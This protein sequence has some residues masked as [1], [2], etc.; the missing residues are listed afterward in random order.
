M[1]FSYVTHSVINDALNVRLS[2]FSVV[3]CFVTCT[4]AFPVRQTLVR[5]VTFEKAVMNRYRGI[6][7]FYLF[8]KFHQS[9]YS[10]SLS[11]Y[12]TKY[13]CALRI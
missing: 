2:F 7:L 12:N 1:H 10:C 3:R 5:A 6:N 9:V 4:K 13:T 8:I 11:L